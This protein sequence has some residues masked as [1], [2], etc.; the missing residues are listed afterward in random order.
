MAWAR[1]GSSCRSG[2]CHG[3][4]PDGAEEC[5]RHSV[6]AFEGCAEVALVL[7]AQLIA[8]VCHGHV[9]GEQQLFGHLHAQV[10]EVAEH[11]GAECFL[12]G[13]LQCAFVGAHEEGQAV[14]AW[15]AV[16]VVMDENAGIVH[17]IL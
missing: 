14:E 11:G 12:E 15:H 4:V 13:A 9:G 17:L 1:C 16:V 10:V 8:D 5:W 7:V 3:L 6:F 2:C